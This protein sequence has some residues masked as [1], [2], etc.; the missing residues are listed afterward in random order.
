MKDLIGQNSK[1]IEKRFGFDYYLETKDDF[2]TDEPID[3]KKLIQSFIDFN[4]GREL[5][6]YLLS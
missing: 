5:T 3:S 1:E 2:L 6:T 4:D